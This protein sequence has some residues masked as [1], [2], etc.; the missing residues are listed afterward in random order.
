LDSLT[1]R[2][3][4]NEQANLIPAMDALRDEIDALDIQIIAA[5]QNYNMV[6]KG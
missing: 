1:S 6:V 5:Q 2:Y 3:Y 4:E